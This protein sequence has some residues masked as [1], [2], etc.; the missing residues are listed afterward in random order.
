MK[1]GSKNLKKT[2]FTSFSDSLKR[3]RLP[4][5]DEGQKEEVL[6]DIV[7]NKNFQYKNGSFTSPYLP[8]QGLKRIAKHLN[9]SLKEFLEKR[10]AL[11]LKLK[12]KKIIIEIE[13]L[14]R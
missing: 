3:K 5:N 14:R 1:N 4:P 6:I 9:V 11:T 13:D 10:W 2:S 7:L 8:K 12:G